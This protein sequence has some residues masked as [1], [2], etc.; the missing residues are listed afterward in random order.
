MKDIPKKPFS[1]CLST[2]ISPLFA[3]VRYPVDFWGEVRG[4]EEASSTFLPFVTVLPVGLGG[5]SGRRL[6]LVLL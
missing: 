3:E 4:E 5:S 2:I 6:C 1:Q